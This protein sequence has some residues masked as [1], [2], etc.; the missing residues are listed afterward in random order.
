MSDSHGGTAVRG[1]DGFLLGKLI[2]LH[3]HSFWRFA[4]LLGSGCLPT[5]NT[6]P[7]AG[8][9]GLRSRLSRHKTLRR[10]NWP[11]VAMGA[12]PS[13]SLPPSPRGVSLCL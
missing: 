4:C 9:V 11:F 10:Q 13:P 1:P 6:N 8:K 5:Q 3:F 12:S 2:H 7:R